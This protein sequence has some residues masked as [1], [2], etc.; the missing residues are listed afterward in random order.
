MEGA[1][2]FDVKQGELGD[3]WLLA[4]IA[5]LTL[6]ENLLYQVVPTEDQSFDKNKGY[7][8]LFHFRFW[9]FGEWVDVFV[10]DRLPT[11][12]NRLVYMHSKET[13][14]FWTALFEKAYAKLVGSYE[15]LRGG[16]AAEA[17]EDF[18]GGVTEMIDI[19]PKARP[20]NLWKIMSKAFERSSLMGCS[21]EAV[22][23]RTEARLSNGLICGHA[24]TITGVKSIMVQT[25][26]K[27]GRIP[28]VRIRNPWGNEAEWT[29]AWS[30]NSREW[31][32][33]SEEEKRNIGLT[34]DGDGEFWMSFDDFCNAFHKMEICNLGP[35]S[36]LDEQNAKRKWEGSKQNGCWKKNV[37]AGGCRNY[38]D[39]FWTNPQYRVTVTDPD[40]DDDENLGT[41]IV[42]LMQIG[43]KF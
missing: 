37:N 31:T 30:D 35:Q 26:N 19:R 21:I 17:M 28:M 7:C 41:I 39:T 33:I 10:D 12:R 23:G 9:R 32:L 22:P 18:T 2:R 34:F 6:Q 14:E 43:S 29:G 36:P 5:S 38:L 40:E 8:G 11:Y 25:R 27:S 1:S 24:Y 20:P 13:N 3:C 42:G 4:A 16:S 15:A